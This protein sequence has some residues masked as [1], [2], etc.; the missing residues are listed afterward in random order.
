[1]P[2][3]PRQKKLIIHIYYVTN[4]DKRDKNLIV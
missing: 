4:I 1:M 2:L 3:S